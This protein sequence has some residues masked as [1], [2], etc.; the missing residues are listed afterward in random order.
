MTRECSHLLEVRS[1]GKARPPAAL[2]VSP[3]TRVDAHPYR[4]YDMRMSSVYDPHAPRKAANLTV[5]SD[6]LQRARELDINLSSTLENALE[7]I[8][9]RRLRERWLAENAPAIAAYN[10]QVDEHG[11]FSGGIRSF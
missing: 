10:E 7:E 6:L 11:V 8:V 1:S 5:N 3:A 2:A 4:S 9:R